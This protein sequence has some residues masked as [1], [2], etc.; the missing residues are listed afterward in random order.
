M[1]SFYEKHGKWIRA[2][3]FIVVFCLINGF[4]NM[5]LIQSGVTRIIVNDMNKTEEDYNFTINTGDIT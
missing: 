5:A 4:L 2:I 3:A 1:K